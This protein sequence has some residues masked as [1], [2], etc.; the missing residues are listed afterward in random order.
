MDDAEWNTSGFESLTSGY[1]MFANSKI[2]SF[3]RDLPS[4]TNGR[5]MF[6]ES[7]SLKNI[8]QSYESLEI[9]EG[10]KGYDKLEFGERMF[11]GT[12][13]SGFYRDLP[14]LLDA[15]SMFARCSSLVEFKNGDMNKVINSSSMF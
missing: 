4:L 10:L 11:A 9:H 5:W 8:D 13:I 3:Y 7:N 6:C 2:T 15:N 12:G 1:N 14:E